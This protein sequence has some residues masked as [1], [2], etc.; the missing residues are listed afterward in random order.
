[1][2]LTSDALFFFAIGLAFN[3]ASLLVI[4]AFFSLQRPWLPTAVAAMGVALNAALDAAFFIPLGT[5]GI[6]LAT[7]ISSIATLL[8]LL[9]LLERELGGLHLAW[10]ADG[11][12]RAVV[13]SAVSALL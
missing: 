8:V 7:S 10:V 9:W 2:A 5:G 6:P 3:G 12:A 11:A 4:R 13:A 1:T